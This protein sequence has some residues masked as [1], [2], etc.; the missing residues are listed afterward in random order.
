[1]FLV[2]H[3]SAGG[4]QEIWANLAEGFSERGYDVVLAALYPFRATVRESAAHLPWNYIVPKRPSGPLA[5]LGLLRA[6]VA[7]LRR[8]RPE[9]VFT[10][11]PAAN[12]LASIAARLAGC[13]TRVVTSHHSPAETH[14][15][16]LNLVDGVAG[17]LKSVKAVVSVSNTVAASLDGKPAPYRQRRCTIYNALP[18]RIETLIESLA[19]SHRPR[20][21]RNRLIVA[22]GRLAP[23][24]NYP[25]LLRAAAH[26]PDATFKIVGNGP[27]EESL[28][29]LAAELGIEDRVAFLGH[30][31]REE[32]MAILADGDVFAQVSLFEGHSLAL[33]EAA[34]LGLP[35][36]VSDVPVQIEGITARDGTRCGLAV[37]TQ[38]AEGLAATLRRLLDDPTEYA[39]MAELS[40]KLGNEASYA[41]MVDAYEALVA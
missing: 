33:V 22:T 37:G 19:E 29:S 7:R 5:A 1:M 13:G 20:R 35:L 11:M 25:L 6:L 17:S 23:Q 41:A 32:A 26:M 9:I 15:P 40:A 27:E 10:A 2:S 21:V 3:S 8:D 18:P 16:A 38:D 14:N 24:K 36:V 4:A 34:K 31:P 30:R 28:K 12:V 39:R